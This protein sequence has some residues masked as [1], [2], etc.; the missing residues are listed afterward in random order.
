MAMRTAPPFLKFVNCSM[1]GVATFKKP[2]LKYGVSGKVSIIF[3]P[4]ASLS[5]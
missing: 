1:L 4:F 2:C 3:S 5:S